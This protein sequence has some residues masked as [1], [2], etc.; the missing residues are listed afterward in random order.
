[1][2]VKSEFLNGFIKEELYV[3]Q[4]WLVLNKALYYK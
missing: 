4:L 2:N 1:M 3:E